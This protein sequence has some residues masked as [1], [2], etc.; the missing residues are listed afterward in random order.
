MTSLRIHTQMTYNLSKLIAA[1]QSFELANPGVQIEIE[2]YADYYEILQQCKS[3]QPPDIVEIG[4]FPIGNPDGVFADLNPYLEQTPGLEEDL[5]AGLLRVARHGGTL[6][7]LPIEISPL[8]IIVNKEIFDRARVPYPDES[9]TWE[10]MV[11]LA[12]QLT[13]RNEEGVASQF[14]L[15]LGIDVEWF[16]P[17]VMRNGGRYL[18]PDGATARGYVDSAVVIEAYQRIIDL[19]RV[20]RVVR[21]PGEAIAAEE[22]ADHAA[23]TF[24]FQWDFHRKHDDRYAAVGL[25]S[26]PEGVKANMVYMGGVGVTSLSQ[27]PQ[28]AWQFLHH[29]IVKSPSWVPPISRLQAAERQFTVNPI[30]NRYL[31]ELEHVQLSG[32]YLNRKWNASRQLINEDIHRMIVE[33]AEVGSTLRSWT[34]FA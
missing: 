30:W 13:I 15:S 23:M 1:K 7:A 12:K 32:F 27:Q 33:G 17:I 31:G 34:R 4:G 6:P 24:A 19:F 22:G 14:G 5:Y 28:L 10:E 18:S 21:N 8:L 25:P 16:E 9:W 11:E 26:M 2:Q 29:Y 20:H 3:D